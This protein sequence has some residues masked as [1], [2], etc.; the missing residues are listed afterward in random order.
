MAEAE[1]LFKNGKVV[2]QGRIIDGFVAVDEGK[3]LAVGEGRDAQLTRLARLP[4]RLATAPVSR[5]I[6]RIRKFNL[7]ATYR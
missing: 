5:S 3:I 7:S 2:T 1:I 4:A 6:R